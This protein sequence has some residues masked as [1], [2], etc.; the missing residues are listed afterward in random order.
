MNHSWVGPIMKTQEGLWAGRRD[1]QPVGECF[2]AQ[3]KKL[4]QTFVDERCEC[5][6]DKMCKFHRGIYD[7]SVR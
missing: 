6:A 5:V 3:S 2:Y 1:D 7:A 4:L